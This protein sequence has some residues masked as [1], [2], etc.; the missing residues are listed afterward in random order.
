MEVSLPIVIRID[1]IVQ[2][3]VDTH[4]VTAQHHVEQRILR[5]VGFVRIGIPENIFGIFGQIHKSAITCVI[6][7]RIIGAA[8]FILCDILLLFHQVRII[9]DQLVASRNGYIPL[10]CTQRSTGLNEVGKTEVDLSFA[11][12]GKVVSISARSLFHVSDTFIQPFENGI[13]DFGLRRACFQRLGIGIYRVNGYAQLRCI[14]RIVGIG[15]V[16]HQPEIPVSTG[17]ITPSRIRFQGFTRTAFNHFVGQDV[18]HF[19]GRMDQRIAAFPITQRVIGSRIVQVGATV[20]VPDVAARRGTSQDDVVSAQSAHGPLRLVVVRIEG[21]IERRIA[22]P[23][24]LG[25][26]G[27]RQCAHD[28]CD[29]LI[30]TRPEQFHHLFVGN[31]IGGSNVQLLV[32]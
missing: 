3:V 5:T 18:E 1:Q 28:A 14:A 16:L 4:L 24:D 27:F 6:D 22:T 9:F 13:V 25:G 19:I 30:V 21:L 10:V 32:A 26:Q 12:L 7:E 29:G 31:G 2:P 15:E 20:Q 23:F 8:I 11:V 17:D